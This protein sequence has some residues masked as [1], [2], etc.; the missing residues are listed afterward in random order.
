MKNWKLKLAL[1]AV[2]AVAV[3]E[4]AATV[5]AWVW[6]LAEAYAAVEAMTVAVSFIL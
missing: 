1:L 3:A 4:I 2:G 6:P 5:P